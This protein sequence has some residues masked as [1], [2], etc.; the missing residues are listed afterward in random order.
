MLTTAALFVLCGL[1]ALCGCLGLLALRYRAQAADAAEKA[2]VLRARLDRLHNLLR[3]ADL[4][5]KELD[6]L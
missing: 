3:K 5:K 1:T 4:T 2:L 6:N